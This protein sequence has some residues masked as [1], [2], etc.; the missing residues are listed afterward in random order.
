M[1][2]AVMAREPQWIDNADLEGLMNSQGQVRFQVCAESGDYA[3]HSASQQNW[4]REL[5]VKLKLHGDEQ[6]LDVGCGDGKVTATWRAPYA[7]RVALM[8]RRK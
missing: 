5:I 8:R 7:R 6:V 4:A 2:H 1:S 3:A